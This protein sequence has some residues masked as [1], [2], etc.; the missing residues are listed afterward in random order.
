MERQIDGRTDVNC[1]YVCWID[2]VKLIDTFA[3]LILDFC[4]K[5]LSHGKIERKKC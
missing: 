1:R 3:D 5:N 4:D 2:V